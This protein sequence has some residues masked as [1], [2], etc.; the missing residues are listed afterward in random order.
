LLLT[1]H[2]RKVAAFS[3]G[4]PFQKVHK[5]KGKKQQP[6]RGDVGVV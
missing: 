2:S 3:T 6:F 5:I 1:L 4:Q